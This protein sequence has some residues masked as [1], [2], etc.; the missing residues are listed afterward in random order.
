MTC[1]Q[2]VNKFTNSNGI[3]CHP[4]NSLFVHMESRDYAMGRV[5]RIIKTMD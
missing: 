4:K 5:I 3:E 2:C 1:F